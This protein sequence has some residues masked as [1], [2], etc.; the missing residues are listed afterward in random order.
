MR[1]EAKIL[2]TQASAH[3][4][5][6]DRMGST[7]SLPA[8]S[9]EKV[10]QAFE[11][12]DLLFPDVQSQLSRLLTSGTSPRELLNVVQRH[13]SI[14]PLPEQAHVEVI[15][16]LNEAMERAAV[17]P[18]EPERLQ[19]QEL[20]SVALTGADGAAME[21]EQ[22]RISEL[23]QALADKA[24]AEE[25]AQSRYEDSQR[26][27]E[28]YLAE[29]RTVRDSLAARDQAIAQIR[30]SL[31]EREATLAAQQQE[32]DMDPG[33]LESRPTTVETELRAAA[34]TL[35][36]QR[37]LVTLR[38]ERDQ[39][40]AQVAALQMNLETAEVPADEPSQHEPT[41]RETIVREPSAQE[42]IEHEVIVPKPIER[43]ERIAD[44]LPPELPAPRKR[45]SI[46]RVL[47]ML[48]AVV[49]LAVAAWSL[50]HRPP[51]PPKAPVV[52]TPV[53]PKPGSI[54]R[55]CPTCP[56]VTVLPTGSFKQGSAADLAG[57]PAAE[58]PQHRVA[59]DDSFAMSTNAVTVDEFRAFVTA[60][61]RDMKDCDTYDGE[62]RQRPASNWES[63][64]FEQTELHPV[65]C[66]SW[67][68]AKAYAEWLSKSTGQRYRLPSAAE[69]EY[70][71]RAGGE[72][73]QPWSADGSGV[74]ANANVADQSAA[75]RYPGWTV[76]AC[77]DGYAFTAPVGSFLAN[78]FGLNDMLG[79]V[80]QWTEDCWYPDYTGA[81]VDGSARTEGNCSDHELRGGSWFSDPAYVRASYRNHFA[82]NYRTSSV[83]IRLVREI[84]P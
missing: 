40:R 53:L 43:S 26:K 3:K 46:N 41:E 42:P 44:P 9:F 6:T 81:P 78:L 13:E 71:A 14:E 77:D 37:E 27:A 11:F 52:V 39:L 69:W 55:D 70:A 1:G 65:T 47:G 66:V 36:A 10:L 34:A 62:W 59:I 80:F 16:I 73:V 25:D 45:G 15:R 38:A 60:T 49:V 74:C 4:R 23:E 32:Y 82:A 58:K 17:Q 18:A 33:A 2:G 76:F 35:K 24:A 56:A 64:G 79:N 68:D 20:A 63:P 30:H 31:T 7:K 12:G 83:G 51:P 67:N 19:L 84:T 48:A 54:I 61:G 75:H 72:L 57:A 5:R 50:L 22:A 21:S 29:L 28:R 8:S